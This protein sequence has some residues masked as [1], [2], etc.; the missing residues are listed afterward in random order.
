MSD[1]SAFERLMLPFVRWLVALK[2]S[3]GLGSLRVRGLGGG[4]GLSTDPADP[5]PGRPMYDQVA[6]PAEAGLLIRLE[7]GSA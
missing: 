5:A 7:P 3:D 4:V 2:F 6:I 1:Y